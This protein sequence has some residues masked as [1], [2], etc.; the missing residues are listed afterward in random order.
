MEPFS[1]WRDS[2]LP[3]EAT[4]TVPENNGDR[5][6]PEATGHSAWFPFEREAVIVRHEFPS[7]CSG[8]AI[9]NPE[10]KP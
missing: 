6:L 3:P 2:E 8:E 7:G 4:M 10:L 9:R 1:V 5:S